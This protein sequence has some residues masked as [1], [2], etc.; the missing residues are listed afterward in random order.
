MK[1]SLHDLSVLFDD[2]GKV[3]VV[4]DHQ[5]MKV[6]R[7]T[8]DLTD[9]VP[10]T[11]KVVFSK[12]QGMGEGAHFLKIDGKYY[13][14]SAN[15]A[16]GF[17]MPAAR[18]DNPFGPWEV[19][20]SISTD[21]GFG[22]AQGNR[23]KQGA[24]RTAPFDIVPGNPKQHNATAIHQGGIVFTPAG[25]WWGY[26]MMDYNSVGRLLSLSPVTWQRIH[27]RQAK[28]LLDNLERWLNA[29][30]ATLSRKS[31][32]AAAILYALKLLPALTR[33]AGDS[34]IEIDNSAAE[35]A[36][37][38]VALGR[39]NFL[40]AGA[41]SSGERAATMYELIG[42]ARLNG[43]NPEAWLRHVLTHI[44]DHLVNRVYD[45]CIGTML[46]SWSAEFR[47]SAMWQVLSRFLTNGSRRR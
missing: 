37:R 47:F 6:A 10:G 5:E 3:Y 9:I 45:S 42:T 11:E 27:P 36:L 28:P 18:A 43:I 23:L 41:D 19:N 22:L 20:H 25:E 26:S 31:D 2:D 33:Y 4:W 38:G 14:L 13:I 46:P 32:T 1:R 44:A 7:L 34:R 35:R 21:E 39:P 16:G 8:D 29:T 12:D 30:L 15:Y 24:P 17:C 40:F